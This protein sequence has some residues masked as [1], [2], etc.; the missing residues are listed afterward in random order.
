MKTKRLEAITV[1]TNDAS[2][3]LNEVKVINFADGTSQSSAADPHTMTQNV[4]LQGNWLSNDGG[5]EGVYVDDR[6][7]CR[8]RNRHSPDEKLHIK[9]VVGEDG[10]KFP[11]G[12]VQVTAYPQTGYYN[13]GIGDFVHAG[14]STVKTGLSSAKGG[15]YGVSGSS[16]IVAAV[17]LPHSAKI[18][19]MTVYGNDNFN[20]NMRI[21]L[22][23]KEFDTHNG[24]AIM[25]HTS[26]VSNGL[27]NASVSPNNFHTVN[28]TKYSYYIGVQLIGGTWHSAGQLSVGGVVIEYQN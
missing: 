24:T 16:D 11:D 6:W 20:T 9:G 3:N 26:N 12:S 7:E 5:N 22:G 17:H 27:Y 28:N 13:V 23:Y 2:H 15:S 18:T 8:N 1:N 10:I 14:G 4:K 19:G 21:F 25:E